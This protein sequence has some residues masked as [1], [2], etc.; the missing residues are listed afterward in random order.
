MR[1]ASVR[2]RTKWTGRAAI[3]VVAVVAVALIAAGCGSSSKKSSTGTTATTA[4]S[5]TSR[6]FDGSTVTV[7]GLGLKAQFPG[8]ELGARARIAKFN[9]T[10]ELPGIKLNFAEYAD[11]KQDPATALSEARRLVTE[12]KAFAIV[13]DTS[14]FNPGDYLKQQHVPYFG[15]AFDN[16]YC[17][18]DI[19]TSIYGFGYNGC[20]VPSAPKDMPDTYRELYA[21]VTKQIGKTSPTVASFSSDTTSGHNSTKFSTFQLKGAGFNVVYAKGSVPPPPVSDYTPYV[22]QLMTADGGKAPDV[23]VCLLA[24]DCIPIYKGMVAAGFKGI[25]YHNLYADA[26]AAPMKGSYANVTFTPF[27]TPTAGLA[28]LKKY[29]AEIK[30]DY[31]VD[32]G[33]FSAWTSTD[34]FIQA[35]KAAAKSGGI[36]PENVQAKAMHQTWEI[37]GFA[38][39]TK[40]PDAV[41]HP[42]PTCGALTVSDGTTW[43]TVAPYSCSDKTW[44]VS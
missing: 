5:K 25:Y 37:K 21:F 34:M 2:F 39:P 28:D 8:A 13:G 4:A 38:G 36:S 29:M 9:E 3:P 19:D 11:D 6:G 42:S 24:V 7:A 16:T 14:Q 22:Q 41:K 10:N 27:D 33:A 43:K 1:G 23:A 12:T 20:L 26:L 44:P 30:P 32:T 15:W 40:Y 31:S 35:L 18:N 17:A